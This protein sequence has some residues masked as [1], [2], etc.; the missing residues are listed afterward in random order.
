MTLPGANQTATAI[1]NCL[2]LI[3]IGLVCAAIIW[4]AAGMQAQRILGHVR[5]AASQQ[6]IVDA[7]IRVSAST[8]NAV[9]DSEGA[10]II[11]GLPPGRY[12]LEVRHLQYY[13]KVVDIQLSS[14]KDVVLDIGLAARIQ[15]LPEATVEAVAPLASDVLYQITEEETRL[16]PGTFFDPGRFAA[17]FPGTQI[18]NDQANQLIIHGMHPDFM[19]WQI[20]GLEIVNPNHL[21]N[22]GTLS[23]RP[24]LTGGGVN[25]LSNQMLTNSTLYTGAMP[26]E[27]GNALSGVMD[28]RLREGNAA[29][30][31][32]TVQLGLLGI[33][34]ATEGPFRKGGRATY[35]A[36]ARYSTVGLL[37]ALGVDFG[38]E[39]ITFTD[40]AFHLSFPSKTN[41][42]GLNIFGIGGHNSNLL[43]PKPEEEWEEDRDLSEIDF[44][45]ETGILGITW[46]ESIGPRLYLQAGAAVSIAN[47]QRTEWRTAQFPSSTFADE[48][49]TRRTLTATVKLHATL[50][51]QMR[52]TVGTEGINE[53]RDI[54]GHTPG[55]HY[56]YRVD[57]AISLLRPYLEFAGQISRVLSTRIGLSANFTTVADGG[58]YGPFVEVTIRP[59]EEH[60]VS[61]KYRR[62]F[63]LPIEYYEASNDVFPSSSYQ[64]QKLFSV[65]SFDLSYDISTRAGIF[66]AS[67]FYHRSDDGLAGVGGFSNF[68]LNG[69]LIYLP[70]DQNST[71]NTY[72][73]SLAYRRSFRKDVFVA[74]N[75]ALFESLYK[76]IDGQERST[77]FDI[78][79]AFYVAGGKEWISERNYGTRTFGANIGIIHNGGLREPIIDE[80]ASREAD[81]TTYAPDTYGEVQLEDYFRI[82]V[83][84]YLRKDKANKSTTWSLDIQNLTSKE[85]QW[86]SRYDLFTESVMVGTQ[87]GIIPVLSYRVDF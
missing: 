60:L 20:E 4:C 56:A 85:N 78:G 5:D 69:V 83:R 37:S 14:A 47:Y 27:K 36:N 52:L 87:L 84:L 45:S 9:T 49:G 3:R 53:F 64:L 31:E 58:K 80:A 26:L 46:G 1:E 33:D 65:H 25:M 82:D 35:L 11:A 7:T 6:P 39:R 15:P 74:A 43:S 75:I 48:D 40:V 76:D 61:L 2:A 59:L 79:H 50:S 28:M 17:S 77:T 34:A 12:R 67:G 70:V 62:S 66:Q 24:T 29:K 44:E 13:S 30:R 51:D 21:S 55:A 16:Y 10:F 8:A 81:R 68:N 42:G 18:A 32:H 72:G 63:Q 86:L 57:G 23:D 38:D 22:A 19:K 41:V 71:A 73:G 54:S